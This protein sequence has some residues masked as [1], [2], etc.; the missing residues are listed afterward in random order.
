MPIL[1][2]NINRHFSLLISLMFATA[3]QAITINGRVNN[4]PT[5]SI[6]IFTANPIT[7]S[8]T[9]A[10]A[11]TIDSL[12]TFTFSFEAT[13]FNT[14]YIPLGTRN[15]QISLTPNQN[16][17]IELPPYIPFTTAERLN[18]FFEIEN[19]LIYKQNNK[20]INFYFTE[21]E[22][23][24]TLWM[25]EVLASSTPSFKAKQ[26]LDSIT[27][28]EK[29][30]P[31]KEAQEYLRVKSSFFL[32]MSA[33]EQQSIIKEQLLRHNAP[34]L[35]NPS[36]FQLLEQQFPQ[37]F[38][39]KDGLFYAS[40]SNAILSGELPLNFIKSIAD[41]HRITN[42]ETAA[43]LCIMGFYSASQIAPEYESKML[44]LMID[45]SK[46]I[47][48]PSLRQL[49][50]DTHQEMATLCIGHPAP[51]YELHTPKGKK[52][53]T[54][55]KK[56]YVLLAFMNTNI[57]ACQRHLR[58][59]EKYKAAFKRDLEIVIVATYQ[60]KE[61]INRFLDRNKYDK[62]YFTLWE[63]QDKLLE[64]YN[65][66]ALPSYYLISPG[67]ELIYAPL[68]SPDEHMLEELQNTIEVK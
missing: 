14:Y 63:K 65:V 67:G 9:L 26:I 36:Y 53:P 38:I 52:V 57:Y 12:G 13:T 2:K 44:D 4:Y 15:A 16:I 46:Q 19:I 42:E 32:Q 34:Q 18:P 55:I 7:G 50:K 27:V 68:S 51:Y 49:C 59:L 28:Y 41:I 33:P 10:S 1:M 66:S 3:S 37:A 11:S 58:L 39:A 48:A 22:I 8:K 20:D 25:K 31:Y 24:Q 29:Q 45:L 21:I 17:S 64:D 54:V 47:K 62:L 30:L 40:V 60:D 56:R 43:L 23:R 6:K 61:N 5:D 35:N